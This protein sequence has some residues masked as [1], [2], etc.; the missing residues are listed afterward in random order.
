MVACLTVM[1]NDARYER[2]CKW[3]L[4]VAAGIHWVAAALVLISSDL[5]VGNQFVGHYARAV[6]ELVNAILP[7]LT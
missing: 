1:D 3:V 5:H 2:P 4:A 6:Q 7:A